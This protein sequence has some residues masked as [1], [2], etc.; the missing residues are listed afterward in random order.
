MIAKVRDTV[1][2]L[3]SFHRFIFTLGAHLAWYQYDDTLKDDKQVFLQAARGQGQFGA[4][5]EGSH[6]LPENRSMFCNEFNQ[7]SSEKEL[8]IYKGDLSQFHT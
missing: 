6:Q 4:S 8:D 5:V 3:E 1:E 7:K 2:I